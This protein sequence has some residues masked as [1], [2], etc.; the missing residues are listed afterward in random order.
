MYEVPSL[1]IYS[2]YKCPHVFNL[3]SLLAL[4]HLCFCNYLYSL[5]LSLGFVHPR[6]A[7]HPSPCTPPRDYFATQHLWWQVGR[8]RWTAPG[9]TAVTKWCC[10]G[11]RA[12]PPHWSSPIK[13]QTG[14]TG[15][16]QVSLKK[17]HIFD[18]LHI[19]YFNNSLSS[20]EG[21]ISSIRVDGTGYKQYNTG[22]GLLISFTYTENIL[23]W[24]SQD[25]GKSRG[26]G[27]HRF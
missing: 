9:W 12:S 25:K 22:P 27:Q 23:L 11:G 6:R 26:S 3:L 14:S 20:G 21:V 18:D 16:T 13:I 10:G 17:P 4:I 8:A 7:P 1:V 24:V 15:L 2:P 19:F 5:K